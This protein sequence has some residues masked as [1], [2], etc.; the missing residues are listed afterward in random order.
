M[1]DYRTANQRLLDAIFQTPKSIVD[2]YNAGRD[3]V[4]EE[5]DAPTERL[6]DDSPEGEAYWK[7]VEDG[8]RAVQRLVDALGPDDEDLL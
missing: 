5:A 6:M 1:T 2:A 3:H 4:F 8:T 7:G